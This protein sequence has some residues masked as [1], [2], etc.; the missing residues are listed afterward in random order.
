MHVDP[1]DG[2]QHLFRVVL[3]FINPSRT[4]VTGSIRA[5]NNIG[6]AGKLASDNELALTCHHHVI[7]SN[8][9]LKKL[10]K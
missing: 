7:K 3:R 9:S 5:T 1:K 8:P 4:S 10:N 6:T 2:R